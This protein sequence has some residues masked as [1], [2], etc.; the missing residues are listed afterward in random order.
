MSL[1]LQSQVQKLASLLLQKD[2][3]IEDYRESGATLSRGEKGCLG[4]REEQ[5]G[6][7]FPP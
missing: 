4:P 1:A 6:S 3:E 7:E 5:V 2:A